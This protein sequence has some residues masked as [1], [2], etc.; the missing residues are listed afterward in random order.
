[1]RRAVTRLAGALVFAAWALASAAPAAAC[2]VCYGDPDSPMSAGLN[3]AVLF[4]LGVVVLVQAG[5]I[6]LFVS[7]R[8]RGKERERRKA[9]LEVIEGGAH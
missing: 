5:F 4:L 9:S 3:N 8:R 7:I 1:M 2:A 6:A